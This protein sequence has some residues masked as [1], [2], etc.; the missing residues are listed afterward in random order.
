MTILFYQKATDGEDDSGN[1]PMSKFL[2]TIKV[3]QN[4]NA[5]EKGN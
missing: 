1:W 5:F 2:D 4:L 3:Q